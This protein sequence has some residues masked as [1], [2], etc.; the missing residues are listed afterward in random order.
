MP[1]QFLS[2]EW[3]NELK[4]RLNADE[5]FRKSLGSKNAKLLQVI[6]SA[7]GEKRYWIQIADG[8]IDLGLGDLDG[9][10]ATITE[11]YETAVALTTGQLNPVSAFMSGK[12]K[13]SGNMMLL[14]QLQ[15]PLSGLPR[16]MQEMD[17]D[18]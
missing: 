2:E 7:D 4:Q 18:Y 17:V 1:V 15:G 6:S 3:S 14:M 8:A 9:V 11:D 13:I 12:L 16:V 10:D 5:E